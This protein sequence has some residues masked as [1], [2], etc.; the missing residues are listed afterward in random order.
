MVMTMFVQAYRFAAEPLFFKQA[1]NHVSGPQQLA[2]RNH[3][4]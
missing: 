2:T 3:D 4:N 1:D